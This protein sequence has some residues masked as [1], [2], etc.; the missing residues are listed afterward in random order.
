MPICYADKT[1]PEVVLLKAPVG[2]YKARGCCTRRNSSKIGCTPEIPPEIGHP[3][4]RGEPKDQLLPRY[5]GLVW[6]QENLPLSR[7]R[8]RTI[9]IRYVVSA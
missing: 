3:I 7:M 5:I 1:S 9:I 8:Q 6:N 4:V 2:Q